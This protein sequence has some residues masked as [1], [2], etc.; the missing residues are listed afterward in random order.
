LRHYIA[1]AEALGF[2]SLKGEYPP[3]YRSNERVL[4]TSPE[5]AARLWLRLKS[6]SSDLIPPT[7]LTKILTIFY[8]DHLVL[9]DV[10]GVVPFGFDQGGI[11][12]PVGLNH[13]FKF[14][15]HAIMRFISN[16]DNNIT[17]YLLDINQVRFSGHISMER[18]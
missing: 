7:I 3:E 13:C 6:V 18:L 12:S 16:Y 14:S 17:F 8:R 1:Q 15:R 11:W 9:S 2:E 4:A 5:L 10:S